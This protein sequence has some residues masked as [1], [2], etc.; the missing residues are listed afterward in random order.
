MRGAARRAEKGSTHETAPTGRTH[1]PAAIA[2]KP[3]GVFRDQDAP[4]APGPMVR[5]PAGFAFAQKCSSTGRL[6]VEAVAQRVRVAGGFAPKRGDGVGV[7][8]R[9]Q[10]EGAR[11]ERS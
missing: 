10:L 2:G 1:V 4:S 6:E 3:Y 5:P 11:I 9:E 7:V 8:T